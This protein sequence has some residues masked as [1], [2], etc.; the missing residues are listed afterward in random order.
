MRNSERVV[1]GVLVGAGAD[2]DLALQMFDRRW[3]C[4]SVTMPKSPKLPF[5][6]GSYV[7]PISEWAFW[8]V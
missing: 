6:D 3:N 8:P 5:G 2:A 7:A 4:N 1:I